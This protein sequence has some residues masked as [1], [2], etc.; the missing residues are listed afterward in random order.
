M[1]EGSWDIG[2]IGEKGARGK[3][4]VFPYPHVLLETCNR[5][6]I[7]FHTQ[8]VEG[9]CREWLPAFGYAYQGE[10]CFAH[11]VAVT[12]GLDSAILGETAIQRQVKEA[13]ASQKE[14]LPKELHFL[15]Q[16]GLKEAKGLRQMVEMGAFGFLPSYSIP[17]MAWKEVLS[18]E[19]GILQKRFLLVGYSSLHRELAAYLR[20][21]G[22]EKVMFCSHAPH[23]VEGW[24]SFGWEERD[25]WEE[26]DV[27]SFATTT[28]E[29][30][31]DRGGRE[32][33]IVFDWSLPRNVSGFSLRSRLYTLSDV[34]KAIARRQKG[35]LNDVL[36]SGFVQER[37]SMQKGLY[38][39]SKLYMARVAREG[40]HISDV[41]H[42]TCE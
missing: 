23:K 8:D 29:I 28:K 7:Y 42:A 16:K 39:R 1:A 27:V 14:G 13:Y 12:A 3:E 33:Q 10:A 31:V 40:D 34:E 11:L 2:V 22:V 6:E 24:S 37:A 4:R 9:V 32:E 20:R 15:F 18:Q 35:S 25:R 5:V 21:Q 19:K 26:F 38:F 30:L 36:W 17:Q 41:L